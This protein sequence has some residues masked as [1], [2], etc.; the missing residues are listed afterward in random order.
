MDLDAFTPRTLAGIKML[1]KR[2]K[3]RDDIKHIEALEVAARQAGFQS[4]GEARE[5]LAEPEPD[6]TEVLPGSA[7]A[8][9]LNG[10]RQ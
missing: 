2:I 9:M 5:A 3:R 1:A 4:Y 7:L 6:E 10:N 8:D